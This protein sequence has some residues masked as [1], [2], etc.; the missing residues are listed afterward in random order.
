M[1]FGDGLTEES[2]FG[3][4]NI[5]KFKDSGELEYLFK[6][7]F[8]E[9]EIVI[10]E[11][12]FDAPPQ[13]LLALKDVLTS[14]HARKGNQTHRSKTKV[15]IGLTNKSKEDFAEDDSLEALV[16]RFP[17]TLKVEW[18]SY[19]KKDWLLLYK[20]VFGEEFF[21]DNKGKLT[22][23]AE[24]ITE[25]NRAQNT[26]VSPRTA[27]H[28]ATLYTDGGDL[29]YISDIDPK[30]IDQYYAANKDR[31]QTD[32][33]N[34]MFS[35]IEEYVKN[36]KLGDIDTNAQILAIVLQEY[37]KRTGETMEVET[38]SEEDVKTKISKLEYCIGL[39]NIHNWSKKNF[40][41]SSQKIKELKDLAE[42]LKKQL[43]K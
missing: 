16:Q 3:G 27:V 10:F 8:L 31:E 4:I 35:M 19:E 7:S 22:S 37:E 14:G 26:F 28:A 32:A 17:L 41:K 6:N 21:E 18:D 5:K 15:V 11:E 38:T 23:L 2:L 29:K 20:T 1:S 39:M 43:K 40:E 13:V 33:D 24:I 42:D 30:I 9:H 36:N 34:K 12:I 25:N